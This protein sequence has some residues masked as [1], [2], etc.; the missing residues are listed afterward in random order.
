M[1]VEVLRVLVSTEIGYHP[2]SAL[3][4]RDLGGNL[5]NDRQQLEEQVL[6]LGIDAEQRGDV[7]LGDHYDVVFVVGTGMEVSED[8]LGLK[9]LLYCRLAT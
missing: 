8:I 2:T 5:S 3:L 6:I 9:N 7:L 4:G 1:K